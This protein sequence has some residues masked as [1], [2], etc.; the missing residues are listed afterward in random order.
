MAQSLMELRRVEALSG[1]EI[2]LAGEK[3]WREQK[4]SSLTRT[5]GDEEW[6]WSAVVVDG[7]ENCYAF[8]M[9]DDNDIDGDCSCHR[10]NARGWCPHMVAIWLAIR[11][12]RNPANPQ[13]ASEPLGEITTAEKNRV[14][15]LLSQF[16][17]A[18]SE[19]SSGLRVSSERTMLHVQF[20]LFL[21]RDYYDP[22]PLLVVGI[23]IGPKRS[24]IVK[25]FGRFLREH[26]D[27]APMWMAKSFT[28]DCRLH[29][30]NQN[31]WNILKALQETQLMQTTQARYHSR[32]GP[33]GEYQ[34]YIDLSPWAFKRIWPWLAKAPLMFNQMPTVL[35]EP[36]LPIRS[37]LFMSGDNEYTFSVDG[38]AGLQILA[39]YELA[40]GPGV[41]YHLPP[42]I[43]R[44]LE[45]L[46]ALDKSSKEVALRVPSDDV[47]KFIEQVLPAVR[48]IGE[49]QIASKLQERIVE[50]P[51]KAHLYL[52]WR[53]ETLEAR[54]EFRYGAVVIDALADM[55]ASNGP[56]VARK[57]VE[58]NALLAILEQAGF[59]SDSGIFAL[60]DEDQIFRFVYEV[61]SVLEESIEVYVTDALQPV[62]RGRTVTPKAHVDMDSTLDWL[63]ISFEIEDLD[64]RE[65]RDL[66]A[67]LVEKRRY[68]RL[69]DG[70]FVSLEDESFQN[71]AELVGDLDLHRRELGE[72]ALRLPATRALALIDRA[73]DTSNVKLGRSLRQWIDNLKHPDNLE[74]AV[75]L[76]VR[77]ILRDYQRLGFQWMK[78]LSQYGLGGILADDM[79]LGKTIQSIAFLLSEREA[80]PFED[81][82]LIVCPA[83]LMYNWEREFQQFGPN[84]KVAVVSGTPDERE[85]IFADANQYDVLITS[86]PLLR[87]DIQWYGERRFHALIADEAQSIKNHA[88]KTAQ[89]VADLVSP[90]RFALT[91]TPVENS[92]DDLWSI[93]HAVFP[94]LFPNKSAF[95]RMSPET[96]ARRTRPFVLRRLKKDVLRELPDKIETV[97]TSELTDDQRKL[98]VGYLSQL[99][100]ETMGD[101]DQVGFQ[102]S[103]FKILA[104]IT[105]LRQIC[106][107]PEL[108]V[109]NYE[110]ESGKLD[111]L[112]EL[113]DEALS[114]QKRLLIFSQF[115]AMLTII[116]RELEQRKWPYYYLDGETPPNERL[117]LT[118]EFNQGGRPIFLISLKAGGTGLNL[119]G[120]DTVILYDLWWNP[121][122]EQQ[123]ADRAHRIG[124]KNVVQVIR[125][126]TKGTIEEKMYQLQ[127]KKRDLIDRVIKANDHPLSALSEE[128]VR[129]L[130]TL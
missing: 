35:A 28:Y 64:P 38:L 10:D 127:Q 39:K 60:K 89:H 41:L 73:V 30:F 57:S 119:T 90:R 21:H 14:R 103:R 123:A 124:Q 65:I 55:K 49:V 50:A 116:R 31:D 77:T 96:V 67:S 20:N 26:L 69:A 107:H 37:R 99:R 32:V 40:Y 115:T 42:G 117:G 59:Q 5:R 106:C 94:A 87:R 80:G 61:L 85:K 47:E 126:I 27:G 110:G 98:Y 113:V 83:S 23:S 97:E 75:P 71:L 18:T 11:D 120:A 92:L 53:Q 43:G 51:L 76:A 9:A 19:Q 130:L 122:V 2:Y 33:P 104:G 79:G 109:E 56:L 112:I 46:Q 1:P 17:P 70:A 44:G 34:R 4:V 62:L 7:G 78:T 68:H 63:E 81:P 95:T 6:D 84:L 128:D 82:A 114:S 3:L 86:Y 88:T 101:L 15:Y 72:G 66:L 8:M 100:D 45:A 52:D 29:T 102:A 16:E 93:F 54:L 22:E 24:Y 129:E 25:D 121:A 111:L 58:E 13:G 74:A 91:G 105:R 125:L 12:R 36:P 108:F 118:E 48:A